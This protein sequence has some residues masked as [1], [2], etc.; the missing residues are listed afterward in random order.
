MI[1]ETFSAVLKLSA[2]D[3][4]KSRK[5]LLASGLILFAWNILGAFSSPF[6]RGGWIVFDS[7]NEKKMLCEIG[8]A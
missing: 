4:A 6:L 1:D 5:L 7:W 8:E 3:E 2:V